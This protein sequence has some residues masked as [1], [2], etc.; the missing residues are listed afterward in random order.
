[1][2]TWYMELIPGDPH[3]VPDDATREAFLS[4][5]R[6]RLAGDVE[7]QVRVTPAPDFHCGMSLHGPARC[8]TCGADLQHWWSHVALDQAWD[9]SLGGWVDLGC[10]TPCC[11]L[12][13]S[14]N[15]LD[16]SGSTA[17]FARFVVKVVQ[18]IGDLDDEDL[19]GLAEVLGRP[20]RKIWAKI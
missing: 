7:L 1:M 2:G 17:G 20:V 10:S 6:N 15:D 3:F 18:G 9:E 11:G 14:L 19:L 13:T 12:P 16:Y 8:P 4:E 5:I